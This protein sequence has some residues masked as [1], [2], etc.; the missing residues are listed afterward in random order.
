MNPPFG[1]SYIGEGLG[2]PSICSDTGRGRFFFAGVPDAVLSAQSECP[3][4]VAD[5]TVTIGAS[6]AFTDSLPADD[7]DSGRPIC[8]WVSGKISTMAT[9]RLPSLVR[10][11]SRSRGRALSR[12]LRSFR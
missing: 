10:L 4:D 9:R 5:S 8:S 3:S 6:N 7:V 12:L 2:R 1:S 11:L